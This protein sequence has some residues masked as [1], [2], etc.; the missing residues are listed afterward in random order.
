MAAQAICGLVTS[1]II[2]M[3]LPKVGKNTLLHGTNNGMRV[4]GVKDMT[5]CWDIHRFSELM[6]EKLRGDHPGI[7]REELC[8][9]PLDEQL[10]V[11]KE[12][13]SW[14]D[15]RSHQYPKILLAT[16]CAVQEPDGTFLR[17]IPE[18]LLRLAFVDALIYVT[19]SPEEIRARRFDFQQKEAS[20]TERHEDEDRK[21]L[22]QYATETTAPLFVV[23]NRHGAASE[24]VM[25]IVKIMNAAESGIQRTRQYDWVWTK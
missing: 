5:M 13:M 8:L 9:L 15:M 24:A 1:M 25:R 17:G 2:L 22:L 11:Q 19:A 14:L 23:A 3:G 6:V 20:E 16:Q 7:T 4:K 12:L 18:T 21:M 10:R